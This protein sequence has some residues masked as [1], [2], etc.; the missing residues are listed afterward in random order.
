MTPPLFELDTPR[1]RLPPF[2]TA[3]VP[4][5]H[6]LWTD[7][8]VRRFLWDGEIIRLDRTAAVV[9]ESERL[10]ATER[11]GLWGAWTRAGG[12]LCGFA[13]LWTFRDP[14]E[15]ELLYGLGRAHW[16]QGFATEIAAAIVEYAVEQL[17]M[18]EIR[19]ST[20][21]PNEAS[22]CVLERLGFTL[23]R[24]AI[25]G[26]LDTL[27]FTLHRLTSSELGSRGSRAS[28]L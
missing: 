1:L 25:V 2:G 5:L 9:A 4:A 28:P 6:D 14:P 8:D 17:H 18:T 16:G 21:A 11:R 10:F 15:L 3:D 26:G 27:F 23:E 12:T 19:A 20:D 22:V 24:R 7:T 13:G